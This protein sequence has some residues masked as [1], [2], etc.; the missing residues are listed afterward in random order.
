[1]IKEE[2]DQINVWSE[3]K[4]QEER[5]VLL[6]LENSH[7]YC[8]C[9]NNFSGNVAKVAREIFLLAAKEKIKLIAK[10]LKEIKLK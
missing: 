2:S 5:N 7:L 10:V 1:M 6:A 9:S 3:R 8:S 4:V